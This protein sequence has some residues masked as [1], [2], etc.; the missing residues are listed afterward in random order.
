[1]A[2][3][4]QNGELIESEMVICFDGEICHIDDAVYVES[5]NH[6]AQYNQVIAGENGY[7]LMPELAVILRND[8]LFIDCEKV[9]KSFNAELIRL[10]DLNAHGL[11]SEVHNQRDEAMKKLAYAVGNVMQK[12]GLKND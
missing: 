1:M 8:Q 5:I 3:I 4:N 11:F 9:V 2:Y 7:E 12:G 10:Y 6:F